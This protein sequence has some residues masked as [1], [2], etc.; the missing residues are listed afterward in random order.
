[1][2]LPESWALVSVTARYAHLDGTPVQGEVRLSSARELDGYGRG[3][4]RRL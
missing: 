4:V 3:W 2:A 1:M